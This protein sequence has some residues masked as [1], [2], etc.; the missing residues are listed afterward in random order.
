M[1]LIGKDEEVRNVSILSMPKIMEEHEKIGI[2]QKAPDGHPMLEEQ[3]SG[4][5]KDYVLIRQVVDED[6]RIEE[7]DSEEGIFLALD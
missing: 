1:T 5:Y 6:S 3:D 7:Q 4:I 2:F